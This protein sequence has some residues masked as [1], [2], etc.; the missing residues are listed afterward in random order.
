VFAAFDRLVSGTGADVV[1]LHSIPNS[2]R[3][4]VGE[5]R[6]IFEYRQSSRQI[7]VKKIG[8]RREVYRQP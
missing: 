8:H 6:V 4:R 7:L 1:R 3:L 2:F 5:W